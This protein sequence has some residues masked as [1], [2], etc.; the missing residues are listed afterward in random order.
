MDTDDTNNQAN[1]EP[2]LKMAFQALNSSTE[3]HRTLVILSDAEETLPELNNPLKEVEAT[4]W[5]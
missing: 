5:M 1:F 3:C 2:A 4:C